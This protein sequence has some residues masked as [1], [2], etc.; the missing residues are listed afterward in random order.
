[1]NT[2]PNIWTERAQRARREAKRLLRVARENRH[3]WGEFRLS[4]VVSSA[5]GVWH[6]ALRCDAA[7][8]TGLGATL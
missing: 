4:L 5:R 2:T 6:Y 3:A 8:K 1:M 7:A